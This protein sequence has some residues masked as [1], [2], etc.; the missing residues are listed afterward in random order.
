M[1]AEIDILWVQ[2][3]CPVY[4][5]ERLAGPAHP[6]ENKAFVEPG[7]SILWIDLQYL[8]EVVQGFFEAFIG[9]FPLSRAFFTA[10]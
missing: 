9:L 8:I 7:S 2:L 6:P 3:N 4:G 1:P 10:R 5:I